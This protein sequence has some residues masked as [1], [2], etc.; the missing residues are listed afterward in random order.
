MTNVDG[1]ITIPE[2]PMITDEHKKLV[3]EARKTLMDSSE[4]TPFALLGTQV[5]A[6]KNYWILCKVNMLGPTQ[7]EKLVTYKINKNLQ[8]EVTLL[9]ATTFEF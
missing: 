9:E 1:G 8:D 4:A 2:S 5:V 7:S 3:E 6:G